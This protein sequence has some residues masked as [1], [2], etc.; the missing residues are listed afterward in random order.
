MYDGMGKLL[1]II[2]KTYAV[3]DKLCASSLAAVPCIN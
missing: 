2:K 1:I 3:P